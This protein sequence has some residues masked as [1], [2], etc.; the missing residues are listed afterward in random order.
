MFE[1]KEEE[2]NKKE[3]GRRNKRREE[4]E[5]QGMEFCMEIDIA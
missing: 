2:K 4:M 1:R 5:S 3:E